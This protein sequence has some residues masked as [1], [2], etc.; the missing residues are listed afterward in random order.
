MNPPGGLARIIFAFQAA[1]ANPTGA[2]M[3]W[4]ER[5]DLSSNRHPAL[6]YCLSMIFSENRFPLFPDHA[7]DQC[8][9]DDP[10]ASRQIA[11]KGKLV[12]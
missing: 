2:A 6:V 3:S 7:L 5:D 12:P 9:T 11:A 1:W 4:L 8:P 10:A